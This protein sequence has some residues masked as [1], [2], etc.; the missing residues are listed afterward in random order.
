MTAENGANR[1]RIRETL[2][3]VVA[4]IESSTALPVHHNCLAMQQGALPKRHQ[5]LWT[6]PRIGS[7][8]LLYAIRTPLCEP[9]DLVLL[10]RGFL[11][12]KSKPSQHLRGEIRVRAGFE[13]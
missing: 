9:R 6:L 8:W 1:R 13:S 5:E 12:R 4:G 3:C 11:V 7:E 2:M 10:P